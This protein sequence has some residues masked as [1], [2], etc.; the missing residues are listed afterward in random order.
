M[1]SFRLINVK[2]F[3]D[4]GEIELKPITVFVGPNSSGKSSLLRFPVVI[5][6]TYLEETISPIIFNGKYVDYGDFEDV[7]HNHFGDGLSF[8]L[9]FKLN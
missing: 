6:Q 8:S 2:S 3:E 7:V 9:K 4:T 5:S 1:K